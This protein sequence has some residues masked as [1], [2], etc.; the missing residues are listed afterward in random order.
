M[1]TLT[2]DKSMRLVHTFRT[3]VGLAK[4]MISIKSVSFEIHGKFK[5]DQ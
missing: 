1:K 3:S 4:Y 2:K 5:V